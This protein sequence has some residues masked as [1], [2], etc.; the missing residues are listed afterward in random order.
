MSVKGAESGIERQATLYKFRDN[1]C[2]ALCS[3][4]SSFTTTKF[5]SNMYH[6]LWIVGGIP[7]HVEGKLMF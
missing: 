4:R 6:E 5:A 1:S 7:T 3:W 2:P